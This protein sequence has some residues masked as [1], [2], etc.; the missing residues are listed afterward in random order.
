MFLLNSRYPLF[1][2]AV[3]NQKENIGSPYPEVTESFCRVLQQCSLKR[4]SVLH[5]STCVGFSTVILVDI[6]PE[7]LEIRENFLINPIPHHNRHAPFLL[8][9]RITS[10]GLSMLENP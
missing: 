8:R 1:C 10:S 9:G 2:A 4:L 7:R 5:Q 3:C 6:F